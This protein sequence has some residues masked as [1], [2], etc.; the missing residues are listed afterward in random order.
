MFLFEQVYL[1]LK[2]NQMSLELELKFLRINYL[3]PESVQ[4]KKV[5]CTRLYNY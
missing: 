3:N 5:I 4:K 2:F 1:I